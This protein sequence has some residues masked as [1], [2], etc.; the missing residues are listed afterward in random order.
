M[1]VHGFG[2]AT[3][4]KRPEAVTVLAD[5]ASPQPAAGQGDLLYALPKR[6]DGTLMHVDSN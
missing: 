5:V 4:G 3:H 2:L 1:G 6:S